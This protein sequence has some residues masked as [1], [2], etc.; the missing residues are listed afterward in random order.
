MDS[1][2]NSRLNQK[3]FGVTNR[4]WIILMLFVFIIVLT[5]FVLPSDPSLPRHGYT[6]TSRLTPKNYMNATDTDPNPFEFCP[7]FGPGDA[8]GAKHGIHALMKSRMHLGSG[9]RVQRVIHKALSGLPVTISILGGSVS[10]CHGAGDDPISPRCYPSRFFQWWNEVFPHPASELT[11]GAQRRTDSAYFSFCSAHHLPDVTDLVIL[12]FDVDD[13]LDDAWKAHFELLVRSIL[14]RPDQPAVVIL[15][16]FSP[17]IIDTYGFHGPEIVHNVIAQFYDVPHI[18]TKPTLFP[19]YIAKPDSIK[20]YYADPVLASSAGH[21]LIADVLIHYFQSQVCSAWAVATGHAFD[22]ASPLLSE[23]GAGAG[24]NDA[25]LMDKHGL[26][27]GLGNRLADGAGGVDSA[28]KHNPHLRVPLGRVSAPPGEQQR[29][30]A[31][32]VAPY[33]VSAND[34]INPLP[35]SLFT[36]SGWTQVHPSPGSVGLTAYEHYW[37]SAQPTS[38]LRVPIQ[39]GAGDVAV[40]YLVEPLRDDDPGS[41]VQCWVDDN[42]PGARMLRNRGFVDETTPTVTVID[43]YVTRGSHFVE[44]QLMGDEGQTV[45]AF[46]LLGIFSS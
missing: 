11:N 27:G 17:Q 43:H 24:A 31:E 1:E 40:Y 21:E 28:A 45:P 46:R 16:H 36:G 39:V 38:R 26:F 10:A 5:R 30:S 37:S 18:S 41:A 14:V 35:P 6:D 2:K 23:P 15:G 29:A 12:D 7:L 9:A 20:A 13:P 34:L 19:S 25:P 22:V 3:T 4:I 32:E 33:C 42:V 44:C 8:V